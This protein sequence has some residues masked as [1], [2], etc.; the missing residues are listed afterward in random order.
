MIAKFNCD[1]LRN[2]VESLCEKHKIEIMYE[3]CYYVNI[4]GV[5][6]PQGG[7]FMCRSKIR[8]N[9]ITTQNYMW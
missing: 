6:G 2:H 4:N 9:H 7:A 5:I 3:E 1:I 8:I